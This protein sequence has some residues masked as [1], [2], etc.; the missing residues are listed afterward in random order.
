[1]EINDHN[2][3]LDSVYKVI[4]GLSNDFSIFEML[5][6]SSRELTHSAFIAQ[7]LNPKAVH[8]MGT[9][10]LDLFLKK[11][12]LNEYF[13]SED[14]EVVM[15]KDIG[16]KEGSG[17]T[18]KGGRV[19][20]FMRNSQGNVIVIENKIYASD[21]PD[22]LQRYRN[23]LPNSTIFYLTL[24][25]HAP[26]NTPATIK[27]HLISYK[28][29]IKDWL[30]SCLEVIPDNHSL[31]SIIAQYMV[32]IDNLTSD[33]EVSEIIQASSFNIKASLQIARLADKA[34]NNM[35]KRFLEDLARHLNVT[36]KE[37]KEVGKEFRLQMDD[38]EWC[39]EHNLFIRFLNPENNGISSDKPNW[40]YLKSTSG[41]TYNFHK[42]NSQVSLWYDDP[43]KFWSK[44]MKTIDTIKAVYNII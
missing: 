37:I 30:K 33:Q 38:C 28:K 15:E 27:Y 39:I 16:V 24:D 31:K 6:Q 26:S 7:L 17:A 8:G 9:A 10:F 5:G 25:G 41:E 12:S 29:E 11:L 22:Q 21:Q 32:T 3:L 42:I 35:K 34:R 44:F 43:S 23:S 4:K 1:M 18:A 14:V 2:T 40:I 36:G 13:N 20:I 19:D